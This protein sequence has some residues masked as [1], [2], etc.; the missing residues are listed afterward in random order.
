VKIRP[1]DRIA[2]LILALA[3][4]AFGVDKLLIPGP[5]EALAEPESTVVKTP[6]LPGEAIGVSDVLT[7]QPAFEEIDTPPD[8]FSWSRIT[9]AR[10][11]GAIVQSDEEAFAARHA[12]KAT[13]L[14]EDSIALITS[15][16]ETHQYRVGDRL[17][18]LVL[19]SIDSNHVIF[20]DYTHRIILRIPSP[21]EKKH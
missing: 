17:D 15:D 1:R 20:A 4:G 6:R 7:T 14:S 10:N 16:N 13:L 12:L 11:A 3:L 19:E 9:P 21:A 8:V 5:A 2:L 18:D